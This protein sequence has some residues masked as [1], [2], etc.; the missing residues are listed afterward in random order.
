MNSF[1]YCFVNQPILVCETLLRYPDTRPVY[2][3]IQFANFAN[4]NRS[5]YIYISWPTIDTAEYVTYR[6]L[7][8]KMLVYQPE[9]V[10]IYPSFHHHIQKVSEYNAS[11]IL[12][13]KSVI[14]LVIIRFSSF[15]STTVTYM[16]IFQFLPI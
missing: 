4:W 7:I 10:K 15:L 9:M 13:F 2:E 11:T 1:R 12:I 6:P 14:Q 5:V 3:M 16:H 8:L